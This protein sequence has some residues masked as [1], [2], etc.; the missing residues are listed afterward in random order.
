MD[1]SSFSKLE[2]E[3]RNNNK[4]IPVRIADD[5]DG[6]YLFTFIKASSSVLS[7]VSL[8]PTLSVFLVKVLV[9]SAGVSLR[10]VCR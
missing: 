6:I 1:M 5:L 4:Q 8:E 9:E 2:E 10:N 3:G 7:P